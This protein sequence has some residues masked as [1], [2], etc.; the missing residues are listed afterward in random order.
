LP[1]SDE[2]NVFLRAV[3]VAAP[4]L[5]EGGLGLRTL[6]SSDPASLYNACRV[7]AQWADQG[8]GP[9]GESR[10]SESRRS[11]RES[12]LL[13]HSLKEDMPVFEE[14]L[15]REQ[16]NLLLIGAMSVCLPGAVA[17]AV[18]AKE[19]FGDG[20]CV[21]LGGRHVS[22][23]I[24]DVR[25]QVQQHPA[26]PVRLMAEGLI[27][28]VFDMVVSGEGEYVI[29]KLGEAVAAQARAHRGVADASELAGYLSDAPG[30]WVASWN[31]G[32]ELH[33][34][35]GDAG[36][37]DRDAL[38]A[39]AA[40]FG[41]TTAF[42]VF[43]GRLT[44]HVFS[45]T[46]S[47][48]VFDCDFCSERRSITGGLAQADS[49]ARRLVR[50]LTA[51]VDVVRADWPGRRAAAFIED[52]TIVGGSRHQLAEIA[53][54]LREADLDIRF[55]GQFTVDQISSRLDLIGELQKVGLDYLFI[56]VETLDPTQIGGMD[57]DLRSRRAPWAQRTEQVIEK[58]ANLGVHTGAAVLFGLGESQDRRLALI[59]HLAEWQ[60]TY[61]APSPV[62]LNWATQH[63]LRGSDLGT[64][65]RYTEWS[66]PTGAWTAAFRDFG[67]ATVRYPI[68]G[69][70]PPKLDEVLQL[71]DHYESFLVPTS[72][73]A[74]ESK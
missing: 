66:V 16:P 59:E 47:G 55:G 3:A 25:G 13:M 18:R 23:T 20:I 12:I 50:Q 6:K 11:R 1:A 71:V 7:A 56:G 40:M 74:V 15:V 29:A 65:Y 43:G 21:V 28:P 22:E 60:A 34:L 52:S 30:R 10:W 31:C 27:P 44:G 46:G 37:I 72:G 48:C 62:S 49:S 4:E 54:L 58:L 35:V 69:V 9:W 17:C 45:D 24:Y 8:I 26:S 14:L 33:S 70:E 53:S 51:V 42:D 2:V 32:E 19:L 57:K 39:P 68:I 5:P 73:P 38:P 67:E 41:V 64:S 36:P 61:G 63:P